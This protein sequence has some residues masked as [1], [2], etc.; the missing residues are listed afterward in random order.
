MFEC[1]SSDKLSAYNIHILRV[2]YFFVNGFVTVTKRH[3][4]FRKRDTYNDYN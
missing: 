3:L 1:S 4:I 2:M